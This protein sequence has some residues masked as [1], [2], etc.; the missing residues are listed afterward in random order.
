MFEGLKKYKVVKPFNGYQVGVRVAFSGT[1]AEK[2]A[3]YIVSCDKV[4]A[5]APVVEQVKEV[6]A[7]AK[8]KRKYVRK[9][10]K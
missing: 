7:T 4:V 9:G 1:D 5:V 3:K 8:P 10:K 2:Y 6:E